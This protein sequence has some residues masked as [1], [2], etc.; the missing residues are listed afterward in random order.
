MVCPRS[1][2]QRLTENRADE[3]SSWAWGNDFTSVSISDRR[4]VWNER[5]REELEILESGLIVDDLTRMVDLWK[6][7]CK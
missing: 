7:T 5:H 3:F 4:K 2:I 1:L 6:R